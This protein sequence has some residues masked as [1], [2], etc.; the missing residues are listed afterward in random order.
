LSTGQDDGSV[1][2]GILATA[3]YSGDTVTIEDAGQLTSLTDE[4][5]D[6]VK[7]DIEAPPK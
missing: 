1:P 7:E 6:E 3:A 2:V 4:Y 5:A